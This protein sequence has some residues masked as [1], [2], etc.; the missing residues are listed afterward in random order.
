MGKFDQ[1]LNKRLPDCLMELLDHQLTLYSDVQQN[2]SKIV[3]YYT[4]HIQTVNGRQVT[5]NPL[6]RYP[7]L[8]ENREHILKKA[9]QYNVFLG[10]WYNQAVAPKNI[11]LDRVEYKHGSCP[12][13]ETICKKIINLPTNISLDEAKKVVKILVLSKAEGLND[14][15]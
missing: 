9:R 3:D 7:I 14:V 1:L 5:S 8:A 13:A 15:L 4:H 6:I 2:R 10:D 11:D 12:A